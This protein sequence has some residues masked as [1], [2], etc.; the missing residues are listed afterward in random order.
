MIE[1]P[2]IWHFASV[3]SMPLTALKN[4]AEVAVAEATLNGL[5][6]EH[7]PRVL[8]VE[9]NMP[10]LNCRHAVGAEIRGASS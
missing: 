1:R 5:S 9:L 10:T 2:T 4:K 6:Y 7:N 3:A 8:Y